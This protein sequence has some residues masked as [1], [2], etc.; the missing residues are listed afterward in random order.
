MMNKV[1]KVL[2]LLCTILL[3]NFSFAQSDFYDLLANKS[4]A[5]RSQLFDTVVLKYYKSLPQDEFA[6]QIQHLKQ[7]A[8]QH[9]DHPVSLEVRLGNYEYYD[10]YGIYYK[11]NKIK[12]F[13]DELRKINK[14]KYKEYVAILMFEL[15]NNYFG[16]NHDYTK[17][18]E[19]YIKVEDAL[20]N[21]THEEFPDKK[22]I[23][24]S[25]AN[26]YYNIGDYVKAK[27]LLFAA[28][29]LPKSW[30]DLTNYDNKNTIG[31]IYRHYQQYDSAIYYFEETKKEAVANGSKIWEAIAQGNIGISYYNQGQLAKAIPYLQKD[32]N[33]C[34]AY[35]KTAYDNGMNSLLILAN[36]YLELDSLLKVQHCIVQAEQNI[37]S[38]KDPLKHYAAYYSVLAKYNFKKNNYRDA[39]SYLDSA[40]KY[41]DSL[42][43]R[44]DIYKLA[45][46]AHKLEVDKHI[47]KLHQMGSEKA[48]IEHTR[49][50]LIAGIVF[51]FIITILI[52]N[53]KRLKHRLKSRNLELQNELAEKELQHAHIQLE[54]ITESISKKNNLL[55]KSRVE[56]EKLREKLFEAEQNE[57][58]EEMLQQLYSAT[59]LTDEEWEEYKQ[60]FEQVYKGFLIRLKEKLPELS[61]AD[62]RYIVLS[63]LK[64]SNK[65]MAAILGVQPDTI[66]TYKHRLRKKINLPDGA[67]ITDF[68]DSI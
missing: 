45:Q 44:D 17:A 46:V 5:D 24:V 14:A 53:R 64:M 23:L 12:V 42:I 4:Y 58:N 26:R 57:A 60:A 20:C 49:N 68:A 41:N 33:E 38:T 30:K 62:V 61:P 28:D 63:K 56:I 1:L 22:S 36:I 18:F 55:D 21:F 35:Y 65:E 37:D 31:L 16:K 67:S 50:G 48:L 8:E 59:I 9:N 54:A 19:Y 2:T 43:Q 51:I 25:I 13:E 29:T 7:E 66:R 27:Q 10:Y 32:V 11:N 40:T 39:Y 34:F 47:S 6:K 15:G 52:I 3:Y